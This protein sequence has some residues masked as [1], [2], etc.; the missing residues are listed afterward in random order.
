MSKAFAT[1]RWRAVAGMRMAGV[2]GAALLVAGPTAPAQSAPR[3]PVI[4]G[5]AF[6]G[7]LVESAGT[8]KVWGWPSGNTRLSLGDGNDPFE[9]VDTVR[10]PR[11]L[12]GVQNATGAAVGQYHA[13]TAAC[14]G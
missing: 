12:A 3:I 10:T 9:Q 5:N 4:A 11:R 1:W 6:L 7:L 13:L 2:V 14:C 8:V